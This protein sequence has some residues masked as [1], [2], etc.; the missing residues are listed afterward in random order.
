LL[1]LLLLLLLQGLA[2]AVSFW[3]DVKGHQHSRAVVKVVRMLVS[4]S[5]SVA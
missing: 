5:Y 1:L 2:D 3:L 4:T